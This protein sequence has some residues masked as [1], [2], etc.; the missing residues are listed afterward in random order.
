MKSVARWLSRI[1]VTL[2]IGLIALLSTTVFV[3][4][5][6]STSTDEL[7]IHHIPATF[8]PGQSLSA[9]SEC[10][11]T[12]HPTLR[13]IQCQ[14]MRDFPINIVY[15]TDANMITQASHLV[16][17]ASL[18]KLVLVWGRPDSFWYTRYATEQ[19]IW[20][21]WGLKAALLRGAFKP[22]TQVHALV[23]YLD[24]ASMPKI[25]HAWRG[26]ISTNAL[27]LG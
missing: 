8:L 24:F 9:L 11:L 10:R 26:F 17:K 22:T 12:D 7:N 25:R 1:S 27:G 4:H 14:I 20:V 13:E 6:R 19:Y 23:Y 16:E 3:G 18:G 21:S 2:V 15:N 5:N